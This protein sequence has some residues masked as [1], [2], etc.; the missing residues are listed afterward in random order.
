LAAIDSARD[1]ERYEHL[2]T[3]SDYNIQK[4]STLHL[5]ER[6][7]THPYH[8]ELLDAAACAALIQTLNERAAECPPAEAL[9]VRLTLSKATLE[10]LMGSAQL[11]RLC[12]AFDGPY[13]TI[14][15]RRVAASGHCVGFHCDYSKRTLQVALNADHE[16]GGGKPTFSTAD[17]FVQ[18]EWLRD[19]A[20]Q[21]AL[22]RRQHTNH[23]VRYGL[24]LCDTLICPCRRSASAVSL[25]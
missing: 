11:E 9:D 4:E 25:L 17:G 24:F 19:D 16:Y 15:L 23:G 18:P 1:D 5:D 7:C 10:R 14:R 12:V 6:T 8:E 21:L 20:R 3:L 2:M 13:D 22:A